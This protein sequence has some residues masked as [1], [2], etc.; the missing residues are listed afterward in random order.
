MFRSRFSDAFPSKLIQL[1]PQD[2]E[3]GIDGETLSPQ[4]ESFL[5]AILALVL[6]RTKPIE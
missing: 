1:G 5:C 3:T 2:I 6:N 4:V